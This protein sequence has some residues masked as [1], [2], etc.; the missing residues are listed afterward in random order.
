MALLQESE[1][2]DIMKLTRKMM[3]HKHVDAAIGTFERM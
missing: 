2:T 3:G 1:V